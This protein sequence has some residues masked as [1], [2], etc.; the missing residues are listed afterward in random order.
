M[1]K[2]SNRKKAAREARADTP[3][4]RWRDHRCLCCGNKK[5]TTAVWCDPCSSA[6]RERGSIRSYPSFKGPNF[7]TEQIAL[8]CALTAD[9]RWAWQIMEHDDLSYYDITDRDEAQKPVS[10]E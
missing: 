8:I 6:A 7:T 9:P 4:L 3:E 10:D 1:G 2:A 5:D